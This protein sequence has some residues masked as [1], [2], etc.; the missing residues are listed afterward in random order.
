MRKE[1][2][3]PLRKGI[4][5]ES[6]DKWTVILTAQGEFVKIPAHPHHIEGKEVFF[7]P[8]AI[9]VQEKKKRR[10]PRW[11]SG[12]S[13]A[14]ACVLLLAILFPFG[15][16]SSA[17]AAVTIDINPSVELQVDKEG[18]VIEVTSMDQEGQD[19]LKELEWE[20]QLLAT[21]TIRI[22]KKAKEKGYMNAERRVLI[23]TTYYE[24]EHERSL[25]PLLE[26]ASKTVNPEQ[27]EITFVILEGKK[28]WHDEAKAKQVPPGAYTLVKKAEQQ[29]ITIKQEE[30]KEVKLEKIL[31]VTGVKVIA[32][33]PRKDKPE[34]KKDQD[35]EEDD[36]DDREDSKEQSKGQGKGPAQKE[37]QKGKKDD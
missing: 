3:I 15:G 21:V 11:V 16:G 31:P 6:G 30:V 23:T 28:E 13:L 12:V 20:N 8:E 22:I 10:L 14:T 18:L 2:E 36:R 32:P 37:D 5:M 27:E 33:K 9:I 19:V 34:K 29:G 1:G 7:H 4:V 25:D 24:E 35:R 26:E 17:Y